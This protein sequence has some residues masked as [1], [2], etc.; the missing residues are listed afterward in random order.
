MA[1]GLS[2]LEV[3]TPRKRLRLTRQVGAA[4][5]NTLLPAKSALTVFDASEN[6]YGA[7]AAFWRTVK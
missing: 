6:F 1:R 4:K 5:P 7:T 3:E 2:I